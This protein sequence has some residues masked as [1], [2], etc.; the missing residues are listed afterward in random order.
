MKAAGFPI[1]LVD[2]TDLA[3]CRMYAGF[4]AT[5]RGFARNAYEALGSPVALAVM[6]A[7][8][9][10]LF[11]VPFVALPLAVVTQGFSPASALWGTAVALAVALRAALAI[12][13]RAPLWT[14][15]A[16]PVAV[17]LMIGIQ[18][19]SYANARFG[20]GVTWRSRTYG[21]ARPARNVDSAREVESVGIRI[22]K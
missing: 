9:A 3:S 8:N 14:A 15:L 13:F 16:T 19:H 18:L 12:R 10:S 6:V 1:G 22:T 11:I 21:P 7:L 5:W 2:G 20:R 17:A 4:A